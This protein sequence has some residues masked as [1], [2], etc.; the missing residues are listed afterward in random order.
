M[1][2]I[3]RLRSV[4]DKLTEDLKR[5][6]I[7]LRQLGKKYGVTYQAI[8]D[9]YKRK[10]IKRPKRPKRE[11]TK[12]CPICQSLLKI[13]KQPHSDFISSRTIKE[14]LRLESDKWA[15][16]IRILRKKGFV[17]PKFGRLQSQKAERAYKI[18]F[19]KGLP[20]RTIGSQV[21]LKNFH[22]YIKVHRVLGW[23]VPD[24]LFKY[25]SNDRK[26]ALKRE[27]DEKKR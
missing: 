4:E 10:G 24:P 23:D 6:T 13:A 25:G 19:Q 5:T 12:N 17:S 14:Q 27:K 9:F 11:H 18:Y 2:N 15:Y 22:G 21:G 8:F 16:H 7:P 20:L 1:R 3:G 26:A